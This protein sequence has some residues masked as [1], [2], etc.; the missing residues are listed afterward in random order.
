M[1]EAQSGAHGAVRKRPSPM[2]KSIASHMLASWQTY[3]AVT[4]VYQVDTS[5]MKRCRQHLAERGLRASYTDLIARSVCK[6]LPQFPLVNC[7]FDGQEIEYHDAVHLGIAVALE[8]GLVVPVIRD[9]HRKSLGEISEAVQEMA[10]AA[11]ARKLPREAMGGGTFTITNLGMYGVQAFSPLINLPQSAILGVTA[12]RD[13]AMVEGGQVVVLPMMHLCLSADH[14]MIDGSVAAR[15]LQELTND[16][17]T[18]L[19]E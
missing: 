10:A 14:R 2:R 6:V 11:R 8:E 17:Q 9:A 4:Y 5:A 7:S 16:L 3:P 19:C 15:F 1:S 18:L 12:I 13:E